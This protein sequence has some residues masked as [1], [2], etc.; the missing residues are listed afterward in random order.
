MSLGGWGCHG[1]SHGVGQ[2]VT[3]TQCFASSEHQAGMGSHL[4]PVLESGQGEMS[5]LA[6]QETA[7]LAW[8]GKGGWCPHGGGGGA[9]PGKS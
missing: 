6:G 3:F 5:G 9:L 4:W 7:M 2:N 1:F 8:W